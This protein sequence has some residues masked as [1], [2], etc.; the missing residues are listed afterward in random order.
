MNVVVAVAEKLIIQD[1]Y[2]DSQFGTKEQG[3]ICQT[4]EGDW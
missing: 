2:G 1:W 4:R 3:Q